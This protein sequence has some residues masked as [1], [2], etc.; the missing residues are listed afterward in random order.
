MKLLLILVLTT[1][2]IGC[3]GYGSS[4]NSMTGGAPKITALSP[5]M[6]ANS[7]AFTLTVTGTGLT[8]SSVIYWNSTPVT[9]NSGGYLSGTVSANISA[10]MDAN[11]GMVSVYVRTSAGNSNSLTFMV[12]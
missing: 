12:N 10:T 9:T 1:A 4:S 7:T 3:G 2:A 6:I 11:P 8:T 5:N